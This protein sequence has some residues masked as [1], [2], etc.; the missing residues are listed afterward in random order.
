MSTVQGRILIPADA[1]FSNATAYVKLE[2]VTLAGAPADVI[3]TQTINNVSADDS[4]RFKLENTSIN[5]RNRYNVRVHISVDG[6][7]SY[8]AGDY[9]STENYPVLTEGNPSSVDVAVT[10]I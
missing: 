2:D 6:D 5:E 4:P 7:S 9:L 3:A 1:D 8:Q 10:K